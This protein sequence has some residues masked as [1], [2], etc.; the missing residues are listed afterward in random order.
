MPGLILS[1]EPGQGGPNFPRCDLSQPFPFKNKAPVPALLSP[2]Q[3]HTVPARAEWGRICPLE[4]CL[5]S[6]RAVAVGTPPGVIPPT[7]QGCS[8]LAGSQGML[9]Q[10]LSRDPGAALFSTD[11]SGKEVGVFSTNN[12]IEKAVGL[13]FFPFFSFFLPFPSQQPYLRKRFLF[14][15]VHLV[16]N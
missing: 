8:K 3:R 6:R 14:A 15:S 4:G 10:S 13:F 12:F 2:R 11:I 7:A 5:E 9:R 1:L 16:K